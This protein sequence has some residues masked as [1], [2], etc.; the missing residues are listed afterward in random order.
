MSTEATMMAGRVGGSSDAAIAGGVLGV[1]GATV[2]GAA[3]GD[4]GGV[5]GVEEE[6]VELF[7]W[8]EVAIVDKVTVIKDKASQALS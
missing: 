5:G 8:Q 2:I 6:S 7:V 1:E 4:G 3:G